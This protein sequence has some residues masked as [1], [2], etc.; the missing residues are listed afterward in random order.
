MATVLPP[1][2][3]D[4]QVAA[5]SAS[6]WSERAGAWLFR[7]RSWTPVPLALVLIGVRWEWTRARP[8]VVTGA[9]LVLGGLATRAWAVRH[10]GSISRTRTNR[11][12]ALM[13]AGPF[14]LVRNPLY[15]GNFG[16]WI[17]LVLASGLL[18]MLPVAWLVFALQYSA[19][20]R[21]EEAALVARFGDAYRAYARA[22]PKWWP[23]LAGLHEALRDAGTQPW[24]E[25]LFSERGTLIAA[26][27]MSLLIALR[28]RW[29]H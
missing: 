15:V 6:G 25:V 10:I 23:R 14:A 5:R 11:L 27:A 28:Y 9:L 26:A 19:I 16:I 8:L 7:Q 13:T 4:S 12:G 22:V 29:L 18:W 24:R 17:G 20:T 21:F 1:T 3:G 2:H